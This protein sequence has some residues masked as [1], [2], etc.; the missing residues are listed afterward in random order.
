MKILFYTPTVGRGG[1]HRVVETVLA[2]IVKQYPQH[3]YHALGQRYNEVGD[4]VKYP[5]ALTQIRPVKKL[6]DHPEQ[7]KFLLD[8]A[9]VFYQHLAEIAPKYDL[10]YAPSI[11][12]GLPKGEWEI[13]TPLVATIPDFAFDIMNMG[14]IAQHFRSVIRKLGEFSNTL[15][16]HSRYWQQHAQQTYG[17]QN[18][19]VIEHTRDFLSKSFDYSFAEGV[20]VRE[21]YGLPNEYVLAFHCYGHK[22]PITILHG[23]LYARSRSPYVPPLVIAGLETEQ[24]VEGAPIKGGAESHVHEVRRAIREIKATLGR[25]LWILGKLPDEDIGGLYAMA[26]CAVSASVSE[27]DLPGT[28]FE[29]IE[30]RTPFICSDFPIFT[31]KLGEDCAWIFPRRNA[32]KYGQALIE[33]VENR[34][35]ALRRVNNALERTGKRS[36]KDVAAEYMTLFEKA[37][38]DV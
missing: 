24:Y 6:P 26:M 14:S 33:C 27:G 28:A 3:T 20:R 36:V 29:A 10:I 34:E 1:V 9:D 5:C 21:K 8:N 25:D 7:F 13:T 23:Q 32:N 38:S 31:E 37:V 11:W 4:K 2:Q 30:S 12:W 22:D 35:E 17:T 15:V 19:E 18:I 16:V